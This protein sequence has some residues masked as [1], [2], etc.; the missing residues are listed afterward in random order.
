MISSGIRYAASTSMLALFASAG[1]ALFAN[2][3]LAQ[4]GI[5]A[6]DFSSDSVRYSINRF[7][8]TTGDPSLIVRGDGMLFSAD[9]DGTGQ[10]FIGLR[11]NSGGDSYSATFTFLG[12]ALQLSPGAF[13][14]FRFDSVLGNTQSDGADIG[15]VYI[16]MNAALD[17]AGQFVFGG[18]CLGQ[19]DENGGYESLNVFQVGTNNCTGFDGFSSAVTIAPDLPTTFGYTV[20]REN[21]TFT[22]NI[23]D[24]QRVISLPVDALFAPRQTERYLGL[25][26]DNGIAAAQILVSGIAVDGDAKDFAIDAPSIGR[27]RL[28]TDPGGDANIEDGKLVINTV[29]EN[30]RSSNVNL[31][32]EQ[33]TDYIEAELVLSSASVFSAPQHRIGTGVEAILFNDIADGGSDGRLGDVRGQIAIDVQGNGLRRVEVCLQRYDADGNNRVGLLDPDDSNQRCQELPVAAVLDTPMR[34]AMWIDRA[35]ST[36]N[37]KVDGHALAIPLSTE[38]YSAAEPYSQVYMYSRDG[39]VVKGSMDNV[40][41]APDALLA[42]ELAAALSVPVAFPPAPSPESSTFNSTLDVPYDFSRTPLT[43]IDDFSTDTSVLG[44]EQWGES[45][46]SITYTDGAVELQVHTNRDPNDGGGATAFDIRSVSDAIVVVGALSSD[47][48]TGPGNRNQVSL[49]LEATI[50]NDTADGGADEQAGDIQTKIR[51]ILDGNGRRRVEAEYR[52]RSSDGSNDR[53]DV[54][55]DGQDG[56]YFD[57][58]VPELDTFYTMTLKL[59]RANQQFIYSFDDKSVN[60]PIP[61]GIFEAATNRVQVRAYQ[62]GES[63][64]AEIRLHSIEVDDQLFDFQQS[65]PVLAPYRP[66]YSDEV[67]GVDTFVVNGRLR[68]EADGRINTVR[69]PQMRIRGRSSYVGA[70]IELSS[71]SVVA[72]DESVFVDIGGLLY[73]EVDNDDDDSTGSVF[74][75]IRLRLEADGSRYVERCAFRSNDE[76]FDDSDELI[77]GDPENCSRFDTT[78]EL[79]TA[80]PASVALDELAKTLTFKFADETLVYNITSDIV[81]ELQGFNGVRARADDSSK[82]VAF[83]DNLAFSENPEPLAQS[84]QNFG[85]VVG[86][87]VTGDSG[88]GGSTTT[89]GGSSGGGGGCSVGGSGSG[90]PFLILL[91]LI[92]LVRVYSIRA[93]R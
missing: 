37:F 71:E 62:Q 83:A 6:D 77:G 13:A 36:F 52:R 17:N 80:Y 67:A 15:D 90:N 92:A 88:A 63:G 27:Y 34:V 5:F 12:E 22:V 20:D 85:N 76:N 57:G 89:S 69:D 58:L 31:Q 39:A 45:D 86:V 33:P 25:S 1:T 21:K 24:A 51:I 93:T 30:D 70:D 2:S 16:G 11:D 4:D 59:D 55:P 78:P 48:S 19:Q 73:S 40:R 87:S 79:D 81:S 84:D 38:F 42:S 75:T 9:S 91:A 44:L 18:I 74:A 66:R 68:M 32:L 10:S 54:F 7:S 43:F 35:A 28:Y 47:S 82:V 49:D 41:T 8:E 23:N 29:S 61:G 14:E 56:Y 64:R 65:A 60:V 50:F 3:A 53:L 26:I 46:S 72:G